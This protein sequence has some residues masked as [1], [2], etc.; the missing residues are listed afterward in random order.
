MQFHIICI[1]IKSNNIALHAMATGN[2]TASSESI[3]S[4]TFSPES[5]LSSHID[6]GSDVKTT[7]P[8]RKNTKEVKTK[9]RNAEKKCLC[10]MRKHAKFIKLLKSKLE[11]AQVKAHNN[12]LRIIALKHMNVTFW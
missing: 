2:L 8:H 9:M 11:A 1:L 6:T 5:D 7:P 10:Q 4:D 12:E 3:S